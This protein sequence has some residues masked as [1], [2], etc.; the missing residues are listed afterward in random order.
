MRTSSLSI[1]CESDLVLVLN[2][3]SG[4]PSAEIES[5]PEADSAEKRAREIAREH[6]ASRLYLLNR[7]D[8]LTTGCLVFAK[9]EEARNQIK[10]IWKTEAVRKFYRARVEGVFHPS[11]LPLDIKTPIA[12]LQ[13]TSKRMK[14]IVKPSYTVG[15]RG[16]PLPAHTRILAARRLPSNQTELEIEILTGVMHQIRVHCASVGHPIVGDPIY[17]GASSADADAPDAPSGSESIARKNSQQLFLHA[18]R[19][20]IM[21]SGH[22]PI[23]VRAPLPW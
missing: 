13:K 6:G 18:E 9:T 1:L 2:K 22:K 4:L 8:T 16:E 7:L 17:G 23:D 3:P 14:A 10:A 20:V 21:L 5:R 11:E 15:I 12:R 19:I